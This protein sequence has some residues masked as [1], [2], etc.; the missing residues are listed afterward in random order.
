M[1]VALSPFAALVQ[2]QSDDGT[3]P[4]NRPMAPPA[5]DGARTTLPV[6][7]AGNVKTVEMA[8]DAWPP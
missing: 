3:A 4:A 1:Q 2:V 5:V 6:V 7:P 8:P